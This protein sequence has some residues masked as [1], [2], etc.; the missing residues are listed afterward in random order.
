MDAVLC[1][2]GSSEPVSATDQRTPSSDTNIKITGMLLPPTQDY[3]VLNARVLLATILLLIISIAK[4][5]VDTTQQHEELP[6]ISD[7]LFEVVGLTHT[8]SVLVGVTFTMPV[9]QQDKSDR[10][11]SN[12]KP[13][14]K[15]GEIPESLLLCLNAWNAFAQGHVEIHTC[16]NS[17]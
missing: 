14:D 11:G 5:L 1:R 8:S 12:H 4:D 16:R 13:N 7:I 15:D 9:V 2:C 6:D 3:P 10:N 17:Q